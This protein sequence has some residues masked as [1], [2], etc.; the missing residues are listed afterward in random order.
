MAR[1]QETARHSG[2]FCFLQ[3]DSV[4]LLKVTYIWRA[5]WLQNIYR[6][7][8]CNFA[9]N[10]NT[11]K[12]LHISEDSKIHVENRN[13]LQDSTFFFSFVL[14]YLNTSKVTAFFFFYKRHFAKNNQK[15][16]VRG[17]FLL[18]PNIFLRKLHV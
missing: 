15:H 11:M 17:R 14:F 13:L 12:N 4:W 5:W 3:A 18:I 10:S 9:H 7:C 16:D 8:S 1:N 2:E 6:S